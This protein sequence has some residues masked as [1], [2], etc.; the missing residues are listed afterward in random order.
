MGKERWVRLGALRVDGSSLNFVS[1][2]LVAII[3]E[4]NKGRLKSH[5]DPIRNR[6]QHCLYHSFKD[7]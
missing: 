2:N 5:P 3:Y 6:D 4:E 7:V 1:K